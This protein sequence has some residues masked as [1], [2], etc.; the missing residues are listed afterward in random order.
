MKKVRSARL[1]LWNDFAWFC[2]VFFFLVLLFLGD[3]LFEMFV[4]MCDPSIFRS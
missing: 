4:G 1:V 3:C 2:Y